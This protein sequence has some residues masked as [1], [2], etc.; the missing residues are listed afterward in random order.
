MNPYITCAG[1]Y[2]QTYCSLPTNALTGFVHEMHTQEI[3]N[4]QNEYY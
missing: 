1:N 3:I 2:E 4:I